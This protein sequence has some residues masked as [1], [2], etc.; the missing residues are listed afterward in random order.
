MKESEMIATLVNIGKGKHVE[1]TDKEK[2]NLAIRGRSGK[3]SASKANGHS[4]GRI[5][6]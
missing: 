4:K 2:L 5:N 3:P 6:P 1:K